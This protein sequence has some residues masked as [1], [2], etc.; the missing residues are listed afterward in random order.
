VVN[1][2]EELLLYFL[3]DCHGDVE[4]FDGGFVEV[5][6]FLSGCSIGASSMLG[7]QSWMHL[8]LECHV[9]HMRYSATG[10]TRVR[11]LCPPPPCV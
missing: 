8:Q 1:G 10:M 2:S 11:C 3:L 5:D 6:V 7:Y 9:G 4:F